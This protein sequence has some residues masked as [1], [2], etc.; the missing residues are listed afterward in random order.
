MVHWAIKIGKN[1]IKLVN[2]WYDYSLKIKN[3]EH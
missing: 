3:D 2:S 1:C